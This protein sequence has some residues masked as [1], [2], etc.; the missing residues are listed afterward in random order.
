MFGT[1]EMLFTLLLIT[2]TAIGTYIIARDKY[3]RIGISAG[4]EATIDS[5]I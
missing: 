3:L 1:E 2:I 5:L 4:S